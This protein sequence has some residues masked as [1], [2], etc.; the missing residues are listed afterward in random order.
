MRYLVATIVI[1]IVVAVGA[2]LILRNIAADRASERVAAVLDLE[3][4]PDVTL[5][6]WPFL[7]HALRGRF[8]SVSIL[9]ADERVAGVTIAR[10][11][12]ELDDVE[13]GLSEILAGAEDSVR[14][15]GGGSGRVEI[16][17]VALGEALRRQGL[18]ISIS[19]GEGGRVEVDDARLPG[20][21]GG[22]IA[23]EGD[24]L[25]IAV[26]GLPGSLRIPLPRLTDDVVYGSV[27]FAEDKVVLAFS[28]RPGI[29]RSPQR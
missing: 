18:D 10:A 20:P 21:V 13:V 15:A 24:T 16:T 9:I 11:R 22:K 4:D 23:L 3:R 25:T 29:L 17:G 7:V 2:D 27:R 6:G 26:P 28:I 1:V 5:H 8:D 12:I 19:L 14:A